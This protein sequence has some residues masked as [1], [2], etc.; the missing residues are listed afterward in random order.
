MYP[1]P[2]YDPDNE[3][4]EELEPESLDLEALVKKRRRRR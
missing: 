2:E 1:E 4:D 3:G